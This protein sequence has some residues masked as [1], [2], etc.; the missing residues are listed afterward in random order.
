[1]G[2]QQPSG[3]RGTRAEQQQRKEVIAQ[4]QQTVV[5]N[6]QQQ[7]N[8]LVN[9]SV[10]AMAANADVSTNANKALILS[11]SN[12]SNTQLATMVDPITMIRA[13]DTAQKLL[14]RGDADFIKDDL[15]AMILV[16]DAAKWK[17][18]NKQPHTVAQ[19][20]FIIREMTTDP[21]RIKKSILESSQKNISN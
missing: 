1:M 15:M 16:L 9:A 7:I 14:A 18:I 20:R 21:D 12:N 13:S 17:E 6:R 4:Q 5:T 10:T 19:L 8:E 11:T 2:N 3:K